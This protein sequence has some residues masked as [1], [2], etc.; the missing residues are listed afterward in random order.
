[1][2]S[3]FKDCYNCAIETMQVLNKIYN[4]LSLS[5]FGRQGQKGSNIFVMTLSPV[6]FK[7]LSKLYIWSCLTMSLTSFHFQSIVVRPEEGIE[8]LG[9]C[10]TPHTSKSRNISKIT[11]EC[12]L[13]DINV[14]GTEH[15]WED[16]GRDLEDGKAKQKDGP[17]LVS[18]LCAPVGVDRS[19]QATH[20]P[21]FNDWN[22]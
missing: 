19:P 3:K 15:K 8:R 21:L 20:P 22:I 11:Q 17:S 9:A 18:L 1:M 14:K 10:M 16:E 7:L 4:R 2:K 13:D 6:Y 5:S 12:R